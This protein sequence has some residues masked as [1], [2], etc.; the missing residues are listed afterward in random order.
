MSLS[1]AVSQ[2]PSPADQ[3]RFD[4]IM[5]NPG[6]GD[7]FTDH[8][9]VATWTKDAG[10]AD[11]R[12][13]PYG[14]FL[15]DPA[16][17]VLHYAQEVFEGM[18]AYR[19]ADDSIWLFRPQANAARLNASA[20]RMMLPAIDEAD[21]L[22]AITGLIEAD[23]RWVPSGGGEQSLYL[24]P[25]MFASEVF[26][27]VRA[28]QRVTFSVIASPVGSYFPSG[29]EPVDIWVTDAWARAGIG[30]TGSAKCGGNYAASLI[31]QYE[32][33]EHGCSQ[34]LFIEAAGKDRIEELGGMN[35]FLITT[36]GRLITPELTGTILEGVT[37]S[38]ILTVA[39]DLGLRPEERRITPAE[40]FGLISD[41]IATE[42]FSC[43]TAAVLTPIGSFK[44]ATD[45]YRLAQSAGEQTL[46]I[47]NHLLDVQYGRVPDAHGWL[48]RVV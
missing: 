14:P 34:V 1:F 5:A 6:F 4:E 11:A 25:F 3:A 42:A 47:R 7:Y 18:K 21:F 37:R 17:A 45:T 9:A 26:L 40:F 28:S 13:E 19:H 2:N 29:V 35:V 16:T 22:T 43:G 24:R 44:T 12:I 10:W 48:R 23:L 46:A 20:R 31:A 32:G 15:M 38:S 27:G 8:M 30:G 41:E 36:D 39:E 33:Y